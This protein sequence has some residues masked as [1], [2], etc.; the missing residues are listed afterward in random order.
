MIFTA[1]MIT[2]ADGFLRDDIYSS[3][4]SRQAVD[5]FSRT[6]DQDRNSNRK[7][8]YDNKNRRSYNE[9]NRNTALGDA[10]VPKRKSVKNKLKPVIAVLSALLAIVVIIT[11]T[12]FTALSKINYNEKSENRYVNSTDLKILP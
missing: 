6:R 3:Y 5:A 12:G 9:R 11:A 8:R 1:I 4:N 10:P 2:E 7:N